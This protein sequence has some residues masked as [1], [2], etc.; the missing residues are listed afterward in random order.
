M[1]IDFFKLLK[2]SRTHLKKFKYSRYTV[3]KTDHSKFIS[4][5]RLRYI[6]HLIRIVGQKVVYRVKTYKTTTI[7][8]SKPERHKLLSYRMLI[9][10]IYVLYSNS[11]GT[12]GNV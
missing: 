8:I 10:Y 3:R 6:F 11:I 4:T 2:K 1:A 9:M 5:L 7:A 12:D